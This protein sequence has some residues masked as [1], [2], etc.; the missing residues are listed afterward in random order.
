MSNFE[1]EDGDMSGRQCYDPHNTYRSKIFLLSQNK[2]LCW[3]CDA[4][5]GHA[6]NIVDFI[7]ANFIMP[8]K[9]HNS[10]IASKNW[11]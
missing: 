8:R 5:S 4:L 7:E 6:N 9:T 10:A 2:R 11:E 1:I 3:K